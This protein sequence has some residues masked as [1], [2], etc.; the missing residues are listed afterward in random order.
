MTSW[1]AC[2]RASP[3]ICARRCNRDGACPE[4]R[5]CDERGLCSGL[6]PGRPH[7]LRGPAVR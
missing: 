3:T 7:E 6:P 2:S 4:D 1:K 5:F